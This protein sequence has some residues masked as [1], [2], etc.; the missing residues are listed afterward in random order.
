[1]HNN[2]RVVYPRRRG[3]RGSDG[4]VRSFIQFS[5]FPCSRLPNECALF[6]ELTDALN[7]YESVDGKPGGFE[8]LLWQTGL[9]CTMFGKYL[10]SLK[11]FLPLANVRDTNYSM[12]QLHRRTEELNWRQMDIEDHFVVEL[13]V[14]L[15]KVRL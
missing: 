6:T 1:M 14:P 2:Q 3:I 7:S 11:Q 4:K 9:D 15:I 10:C 12:S 8:F 13:L 5:Y